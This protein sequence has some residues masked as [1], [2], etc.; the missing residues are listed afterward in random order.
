M[1]HLLRDRPAVDGHFPVAAKDVGNQMEVRSPRG[2]GK[3]FFTAGHLHED[4]NTTAHTRGVP[5]SLDAKAGQT[6]HM[7]AGPVRQR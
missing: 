1:D 3:S 6:R 5:L 7:I 2:T 4:D